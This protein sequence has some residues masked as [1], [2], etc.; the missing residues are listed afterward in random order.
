MPILIHAVGFE[1]DKGPYMGAWQGRI[2]REYAL[3]YVA[4]G[5]GYFEAPA[6]HRQ[7][8]PAGC[9]LYQPPGIWHC[10][11]PD[12]GAAWDEYW[13]MFNQQEAAR[14]FGA[15][16]VLRE[17]GI[18]VTGPNRLLEELFRECQQRWFYQ[19]PGV[20]AATAVLLHRILNELYQARLD[21]EQ[22][23]TD[24]ELARAEA[25]LR[26]A[27][28]EEAADVEAIAR[29]VGLSYHTFRQRFR[30]YTGLAP[31]QYLLACKRERAKKLLFQLTLS[32]KE[33][34]AGVGMRDP[35]YFSRFFRRETGLSPTAFR[36]RYAATRGGASQAGDSPRISTV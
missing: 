1:R 32:I 26:R 35:Y 27:V 15:A 17:P 11:D 10:N 34:A 8:V 9:A 6:G 36:E 22:E 30:E 25:L 12:D 5:T 33:V 29:T 2:M 18:F 21:R 13:V 14:R 16:L 31:K 4:R 23:R 20:E 19:E 28:G 24:P 3:S 7:T